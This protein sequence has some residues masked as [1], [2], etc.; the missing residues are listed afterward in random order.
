MKK[1]EPIFQEG[2]KTLLKE[3]PLE[4]INVIML[5][6]LVKSNRQTFYYHFR[7]ISDVVDSTFLKVKIGYGKKLL[8]YE[9]I[10]KEM[11]NYISQNY[12]YVTAINKSYASDKL[13]S[14]MFSYFYLKVGN[15]LKNHNISGADIT[16]YISVLSAQELVFWISNKRKEKAVLLTK[17][18]SAIWHYLVNQYQSDLKRLG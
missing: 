10:L 13:Y 5:C 8:D 14:F 17:R 9:S 4:E 16:R 12:Q 11:I 3:K 18:L 2:L 15:L 7:D 6:D 1:I